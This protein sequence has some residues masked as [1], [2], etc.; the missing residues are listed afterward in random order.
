MNGYAPEIAYQNHLHVTDLP[1]DEWK[2][3]AHINEAARAAD[4]DRLFSRR[5]RAGRPQIGA[6]EHSD[7]RDSAAGTLPAVR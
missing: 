3:R 5:I 6:G 4:K 1:F 7:A 2:R